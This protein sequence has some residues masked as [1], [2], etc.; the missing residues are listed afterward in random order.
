M[1]NQKPVRLL[2][3][4]REKWP[5]IWAPYFTDRV[6]VERATLETG[7][8]A[9]AG[10]EDFGAVERKTIPD[11]LNCLG[12][13]RIRFIKELQR[14]RYC[15]S[16]MVIIEGDLQSLIL[17]C[18]ELH[19]NSI[20]ASLASWQAQYCPFFFAST[21]ELA[22]R[23]AEYFLLRPVKQAEKIKKAFAKVAA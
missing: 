11:M 20:L 21:P 23:T 19:P 18:R 6:I 7:D 16:F 12:R 15:G 5:F 13:D 17:Q 2:V 3:D 9:V 10:L 14:A 1:N 22:A 8:V 4:S